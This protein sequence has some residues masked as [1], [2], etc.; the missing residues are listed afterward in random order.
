MITLTPIAAEKIK[1]FSQEAGR[2]TP[3][4]RMFLEPGRC[5]GFQYGMA[6]GAEPA[7][8]DLVIESAGIRVV[9]DSASFPLL[10]GVEVDYVESLMQTGFTVR[11]P[12]ATSTCACGQ[13][14]DVA[15]G[16]GGPRTL[17]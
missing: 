10:S 9:V 14:F 6:L 15:S 8:G 2:G 3:A 11:N 5:S 12:N 13:S 4:L 1:L 17:H 16:E 7:E